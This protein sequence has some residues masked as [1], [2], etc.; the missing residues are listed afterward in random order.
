MIACESPQRFVFA[1]DE[2]RFDTESLNVEEI[3]RGRAFFRS[4]G[5]CSFSEPVND[6][7]KLGILSS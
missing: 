5:S 7:L 3:A 6:L 2:F 1:A 4:Y